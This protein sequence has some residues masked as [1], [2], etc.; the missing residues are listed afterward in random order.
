MRLG[1]AVL[2]L[3]L[4]S[5]TA[6]GIGGGIG[7]GMGGGGHAGGSFGGGLEGGGR[8]AGALERGFEGGDRAA[9]SF[10]GRFEGGG[11]AGAPLGAWDGRGMAGEERESAGDA[12][13]GDPDH[14]RSLVRGPYAPYYG[15]GFYDA[16]PWNDPYCNPYSPSYDSQDCD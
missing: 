5:G 7:G 10:D 9:G 13:F 16:G 11:H 4:T 14:D 8:A 6:W 1:C 12:R 2:V 3:A 15:G